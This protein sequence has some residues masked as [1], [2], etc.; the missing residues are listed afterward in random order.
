MSSTQELIYF[1]CKKY[2]YDTIL[3][4]YSE[5]ISCITYTINKIKILYAP[6]TK[7]AFVPS[8]T[9]WLSRTRTNWNRY[10]SWNRDPT[11]RKRRSKPAKSLFKPKLVARRN[12]KENVRR[13]SMTH[14]NWRRRR[15]HP[16]GVEE[17]HKQ[18]RGAY[19]S[20]GSRPNQTVV[21]LARLASSITA[22]P[23]AKV[24]WT[25]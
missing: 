6:K 5:L 2:I 20:S 15:M 16:G 8:G 11:T 17:N 24:D 1:L 23:A 22:R 19:Y 10:W 7:T 25:L 14:Q 18:G 9:S 13:R 12:R 4:M 3:L 21:G